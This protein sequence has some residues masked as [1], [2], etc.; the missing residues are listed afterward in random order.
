MRLPGVLRLHGPRAA[1]GQP[2]QHSD[3]LWDASHL[4]RLDGADR[5]ERLGVGCPHGSAKQ[6]VDP[7]PN[8][9]FVGRLAGLE[10]FG[11]DGEAPLAQLDAGSFADGE[12]VV[13]QFADQADDRIVRRCGPQPGGEEWHRVPWP[14]REVTERPVRRFGSIP[15]QRLPGA[16]QLRRVEANALA[17]V[18][19]AETRAAQPRHHHA[20]RQRVAVTVHRNGGVGRRRQNRKGNVRSSHERLRRIRGARETTMLFDYIPDSQAME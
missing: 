1:L 10:Q 4:Q 20:R 8:I 11:V 7:L 18:R 9:Q 3:G 12:L 15:A 17:G 13:V 16:L 19:L 14:C 6:A 5:A 2:C